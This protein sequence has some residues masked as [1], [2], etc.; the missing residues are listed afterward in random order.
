MLSLFPVIPAL[1]PSALLLYESASVGII[2]SEFTSEKFNE[3]LVFSPPP[4]N[5]TL[6]VKVLPI[7][8]KSFALFLRAT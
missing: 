1:I 6:L 7:S 3:K 8:K 4:L 2:P 5:L